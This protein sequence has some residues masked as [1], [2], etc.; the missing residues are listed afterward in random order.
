MWL[1]K[2]GKDPS[3]LCRKAWQNL[4]AKW[5]IT[6]VKNIIVKIEK[7]DSN[8]Q[9][10]NISWLNRPESWGLAASGSR[11]VVAKSVPERTWGCWP[12]C[13]PWRRTL[14]RTPSTTAAL[15]R[16]ASALKP[17][18]YKKSNLGWSYYN[19]FHKR[20]ILKVSLLV[21]RYWTYQLFAVPIPAIGFDCGVWW[22]V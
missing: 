21:G 18:N 13:R 8:L 14:R 4:K 9:A 22:C 3:E 5:K 12:G 16:K 17:K 20:D 2:L 10:P 7:L 19:F 6:M 15:S 1:I 11:S